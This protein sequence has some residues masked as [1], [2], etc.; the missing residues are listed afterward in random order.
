MVS[1]VE[2]WPLVAMQI[3]SFLNCY[4]PNTQYSRDAALVTQCLQ[5]VSVLRKVQVYHEWMVAI[6]DRQSVSDFRCHSLVLPFFVLREMVSHAE[7]QLSTQLDAHT[8]LV[9]LTVFIKFL[10]Q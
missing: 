8:A 5:Q 7:E 4:N 10:L 6:R 3:G 2:A 1:L 9:S